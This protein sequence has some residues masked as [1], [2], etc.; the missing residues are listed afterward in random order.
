MKQLNVKLI[1]LKRKKYAMERKYT[2]RD[3]IPVYIYHVYPTK[4][5]GNTTLS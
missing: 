1:S 4:K 5:N 2:D 3:N